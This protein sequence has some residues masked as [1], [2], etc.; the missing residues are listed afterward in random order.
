MTELKLSMQLEEALLNFLH[1][2]SHHKQPPTLDFTALA[3]RYHQGV[4]EPLRV[5]GALTLDDLLGIDTQKAKLVQNTRQFLAGLPA[6]HVLLTGAR[7]AGKSSLVRALLH[8][9]ADE[10]LR[11]IEVSKQDLSSLNALLTLIET[12]SEKYLIYCDDLAFNKD[13]DAYRNLKSALDGS[14]ASVGDNFLIVATSNRKHLV[15]QYMQDNAN[16]YNAARAGANTAQEINPLEQ[17][18][19]TTSLAERFGL[20]LSFHP[21]SQDDYLAIVRHNVQQAGL[22]YDDSV[23]AEAVKWAASRGGRSGRV[24]KQFGLHWVGKM[25]LE[26]LDES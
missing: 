7:G 11:I 16:V 21:M 2:F 26:G 15:P 6:N 14:L 12:R 25:K 24:A 4:L 5:N 1:D 17:I 20:W 9:F 10:G 19:E 23:K 8:K 18:D 13:D 22:V 3:Y